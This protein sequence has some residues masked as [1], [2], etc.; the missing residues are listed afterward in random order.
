[1]LSSFHGLLNKAANKLTNWKATTLCKARRAVLIQSNL[2]ALPAHTMQCF[3]LPTSVTQK[4][5]QVNRNFFGKN[6]PLKMDSYLLL[7]T[8]FANQKSSV[9]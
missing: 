1:M 5:D 7:G 6:F 8:R 9:G 3:K 2:K 4:M